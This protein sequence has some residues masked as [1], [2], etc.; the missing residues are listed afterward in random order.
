M[1]KYIID[2][3]D[4]KNK[5]QVAKE[6]DEINEIDKDFR[7]IILYVFS[8]LQNGIMYGNFV[9][10]TFKKKIVYFRATFCVK[11][12]IIYTLHKHSASVLKLFYVNTKKDYEELLKLLKFALSMIG[13]E[14]DS[15][16]TS[17]E[18]FLSIKK[19]ES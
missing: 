7:T 6:R 13:M 18:I 15:N 11:N 4:L 1:E 8:E 2:Y 9:D 16:P 5:I 17:F 10:H 3:E 14:L 12:L 19:G